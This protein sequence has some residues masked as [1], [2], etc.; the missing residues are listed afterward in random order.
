M[1]QIIENKIEKRIYGK[2][3]GWV[4]SSTDFADLGG[5][6]AI[7]VALHRIEARGKIRRVRRG[8]YEFPKFSK[9]LGH[10][11][12]T[13]IDQ[14]AQALSRKFG[15]HIQPG[16]AM[17]ANLLAL[18]AQVPARAIYLS[19]GPNRSYRVGKTTLV[20]K[21]TAL[22]ETAFKY[23]ESG[24]IV[25]GLKFLG[26]KRVTPEVIATVRRSAPAKLWKRILA[27]TKTATGWVY[28]A[29]Q[30]IAAE[31]DDEQGR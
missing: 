11:L 15:W 3:R 13:N 23:R 6:S 30:Q 20:F 2:R 12:S 7:D 28:A 10:T 8:L 18:S 22:K 26:Q 14:V 25:Q 4:F 27:D 31:G 5:R 9:L 1:T 19:D 24:L 21:H 16:G 17:A 29:I